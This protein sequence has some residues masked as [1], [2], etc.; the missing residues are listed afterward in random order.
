M[1]SPATPPAPAK[2]DGSNPDACAAAELER[3]ARPEAGADEAVLV[4]VAPA[5]ADPAAHGK[6]VAA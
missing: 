5:R 6:G 4:G 2:D 1:R 3:K